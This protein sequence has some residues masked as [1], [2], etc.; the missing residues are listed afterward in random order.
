MILALPLGQH[1]LLSSGRNRSTVTSF[2]VQPLDL[3]KTTSGHVLCLKPSPR[4]MP[5]GDD[6]VDDLS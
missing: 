2:L 1:Q 3:S 6:N 4:G 5:H